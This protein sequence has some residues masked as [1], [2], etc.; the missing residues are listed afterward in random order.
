MRRVACN[1]FEAYGEIGRATVRAGCFVDLLAALP[2]T[3]ARFATITIAM[4]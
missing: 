1:F 3:Q 4:R 2:N